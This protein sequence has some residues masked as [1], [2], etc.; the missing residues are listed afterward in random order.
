MSHAFRLPLLLLVLAA[1]AALA[2]APSPAPAASREGAPLSLRPGETATVRLAGVTRV[3]VGDASVVD[4]KADASKVEVTAH[5]PGRT[6]LLVWD[7]T[8]VRNSYTVEVTGSA[9]A[10]HSPPGAP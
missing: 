5:S 7:S 6:T 4:V 3:A 2:Q 8:G 9:P 10:A 1:P